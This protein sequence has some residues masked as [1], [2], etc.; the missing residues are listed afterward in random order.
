LVG[1][2]GLERIILSEEINTEATSADGHELMSPY[3][4]MTAEALVFQ[5]LIH[6]ITNPSNGQQSSSGQP[7]L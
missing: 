6:I 7:F 5:I 1:P 2:L 3:L 4:I